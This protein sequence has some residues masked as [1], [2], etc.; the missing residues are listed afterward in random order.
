MVTCKLLV[1]QRVPGKAAGGKGEP[2]VLPL[3]EWSIR[4]IL[5]SQIAVEGGG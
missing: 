2:K 5:L 1:S 3:K 4:R